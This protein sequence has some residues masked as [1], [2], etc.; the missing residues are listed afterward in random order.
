MQDGAY[1]VAAGSHT[2]GPNGL[3]DT[4]QATFQKATTYCAAHKQK[5]A[6][7]KFDNSVGI[8]TYATKPIFRCN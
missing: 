4:H 7:E 2:L 1:S 6:V 3:G 8:N 5:A